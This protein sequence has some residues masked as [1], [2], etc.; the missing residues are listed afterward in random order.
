VAYYSSGLRA[1]FCFRRRTAHRRLLGGI[2]EVADEVEG[3]LIALRAEVGVR[4]V[5]NKDLGSGRAHISR[6]HVEGGEPHVVL[7]EGVFRSGLRSKIIKPGPKRD[8]QTF[9][10]DTPDTFDT[11]CRN[12]KRCADT[13][14]TFD[15]VCRNKK[16]CADTP[17]TFHAF[18]L[19]ILP[20][21]QDL[22]P[23]KS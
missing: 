15:T 4:S 6:G 22:R 14:D 17:D 7:V 3:A 16:R 10:A 20:A 13:P 1:M 11:V 18:T 23:P 2:P 21:R 8:A 19:S 12:K 9:C 5:L